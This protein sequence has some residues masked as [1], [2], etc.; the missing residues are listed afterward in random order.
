MAFPS[1]RTI[2][3]LTR[4]PSVVGREFRHLGEHVLEH[5]LGWGDDHHAR[6]EA[7]RREYVRCGREIHVPIEELK[8]NEKIRRRGRPGLSEMLRAVRDTSTATPPPPPLP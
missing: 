4:V 1:P 5:A 3:V 8:P 6:I 2:P 7:I